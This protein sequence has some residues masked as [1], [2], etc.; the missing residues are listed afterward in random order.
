MSNFHSLFPEIQKRVSGEC[1]REV[2]RDTEKLVGVPNPYTTPGK[3]HEDAQFYWDTFFI[4]MGLI[5]LRQIDQARMNAENLIF[6][7]RQFGYVPA[8]TLKSMTAHSQ[9]PLLPWIVRDV[10]RA[11]GDKDWLSRM[12][13]DVKN[14]FIWWTK[15]P[16]TSP[17]G[18]YRF[19]ALNDATNAMGE[20]TESMGCWTRSA[21]FDG[22]ENYNPVDLNALLFRNAKLIHDLQME[23]DGKADSNLLQKSS[24]IKSMLETCWD[25]SENF[26]FDNNFAEKKLSPVKALAGFMPLFVK[27]VDAERA[28]QLQQQV[29]SF[30]AP[31]GV[32]ITDKAYADTE[33]PWDHPL[34]CAPY[35]Y[36]LTKALADHDF[37]EDAADIG[38]NWLQMVF[39][40]YE[41]T[42]EMW[43]WYNVKKKTNQSTKKVRNSPILGWTAGTYIALVDTLGLE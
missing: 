7:S 24:Q 5:R 35:V 1:I 42:G 30:T 25:E 13:P 15:K 20:G 4:N 8:S 16:H 32:S 29:A 6:L 36:F 17:V 37:M 14:E 10:Y 38:M 43:S 39:D 33:S 9:M 34:I 12:L 41:K 26:Y 2:T 18:L 23:A 28:A 40:T 31:G 22:V 19:K 3:E 21:R 27:M 11:T